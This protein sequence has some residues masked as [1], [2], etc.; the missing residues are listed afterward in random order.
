MPFDKATEIGYAVAL[1]IQIIGISIVGSIICLVITLFFG[2]CWYVE[3]FIDDL[4]TIRE[5]IDQVWNEKNGQ[6]EIYLNC[7][8]FSLLKEF[9][10]FEEKIFM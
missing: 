7:V 8:T 2:V 9:A 1:S 3:S 10:V 6:S 5:M 4:L